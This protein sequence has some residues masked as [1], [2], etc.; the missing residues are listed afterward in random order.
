[1]LGAGDLG[2]NAG[3]VES[4]LK[5]VLSLIPIWNAILLIDEADVFLEKRGTHDLE[6]NAIVAVFLREIEY[7]TS[8]IIRLIFFDNRIRYFRGILFLT[9]NRVRE[10]DHAFQSRIHISLHY[11]DLDWKTR[12]LLWKAFLDKSRSNPFG[13]EEISPNNMDLLAKQDLNGRQ[14]KNVVKVASSLAK[15][16]KAPLG[17]GQLVRTMNL[18]G[19]NLPKPVHPKESS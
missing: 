18:A 13:V 10:F 7:V 5:D 3:T 19:H 9:T 17:Y 14:I 4:R 6:R 15:F 8:T 2:T 16:E 11:T 12:A 1:M